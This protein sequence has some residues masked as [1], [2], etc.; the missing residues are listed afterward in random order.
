MI[1]NEPTTPGVPEIVPVDA[2]K[3][4]PDGRVPV[5]TDQVRV[6]EPPLAFSVVEYAVLNTPDGIDVVVMVRREAGRP[7][8]RG[9]VSTLRMRSLPESAMYRLP[10]PSRDTPCGKFICALDAGPPS[11]ENPPTPVPAM[12]V[13]VPLVST[14]RMLLPPPVA[15]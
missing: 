13:I 15:I 14:R 12:V 5:A 3:L 7:A 2:F 9:G 4:T 10:A 11:P 8:G 6:P 1:G